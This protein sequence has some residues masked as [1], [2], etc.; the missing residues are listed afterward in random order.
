MGSLW[1]I[2][3][4]RKPKNKLLQV[5]IYLDHTRTSAIRAHISIPGSKSES[6]R[7]LILQQ[8]YPAL[9]IDNIS[10]SDDSIRV[11]NA[12]QSKNK[13]IDIGHAG[14]AMRFLT[15]Y[16]A[17]QHQKR[18]VLTGSDRMKQRPIGV[19]VN[20]LQ[21]LDSSI[22]YIEKDGF[23]PIE[24][25]GKE[26]SKNK[27]Q[28]QADVS[29]QYIS[30]LLL[31]A[32]KLKNGLELTLTG[33]VTSQPY[34]DMTLALL[35]TIGINTSFENNSI[36]IKAKKQI[37]RPVKI[38]VEP[39]WSSA[40]YYYSLAALQKNAK[41]E[42]TGFRQN[43]LQGDRFVADIYTK[44]GVQTTFTKNGILIESISDFIPEKKLTF[45]LNKTPDLAQT[46]AVSCVGLGIDC[47]LS[48]L[49]TLAIKETNR[50]EAL[51]NEL[52][53]LGAAIRITPDSLTLKAPKSLKKNCTIKTYQDHR[54]AMAFAPL[55]V[56]VPLI[57]ED[58]DVVSK[59]YPGFWEDWKLV[60]Q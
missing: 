22:T 19:L 28:I 13:I 20:A 50:L 31:I 12:L 21:Q 4:K 23:P 58:K 40:S 26:L 2:L 48:G 16:F 42:L 39:D 5:Q 11:Q 9:E 47:H 53:K 38:T 59:S 49:H 15:A 56:L 27:L 54:M 25:L 45:D 17:I 10:N 29:S 57:I 46:L 14:T 30:A 52:E 8:L 7:L 41:I 18:T 33:K 36:R 3:P 24:I 37:E 35:N 32:P 60:L 44:L 34:I 51:K 43:S 1:P 6:N 55:S